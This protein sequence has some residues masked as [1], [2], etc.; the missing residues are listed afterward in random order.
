MAPEDGNNLLEKFCLFGRTLLKSN[1]SDPGPDL[2]TDSVYL[3]GHSNA[4]KDEIPTRL[5][6]THWALTLSSCL[7]EEY[8]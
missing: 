4:K 2:R 1:N 8:W 3:A 5:M 7:R 6:A